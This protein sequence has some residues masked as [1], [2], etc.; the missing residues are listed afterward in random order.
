VKLSEWCTQ[1]SETGYFDTFRKLSEN[2]NVCELP[3]K[4][5]RAPPA[6]HCGFSNPSIL[7]RRIWLLT[8]FIMT[9]AHRPTFDPV[10]L[11]SRATSYRYVDKMV[12]PGEGGP[13]RCGISSTAYARAYPSE[14]SVGRSTMSS[15]RPCI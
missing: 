6:F 9:T 1:S 15:Y 14:S 5:F 12:G 10:S 13:A 4:I 3:P 8:T 7:L 11:S 2:T